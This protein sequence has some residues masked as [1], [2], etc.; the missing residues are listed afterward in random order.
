MND[1][2]FKYRM[3]LNF[4]RIR[5]TE[6]IAGYLLFDDHFFVIFTFDSLFLTYCRNRKS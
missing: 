4:L 5:F 2:R 3:D 1:I 6:M